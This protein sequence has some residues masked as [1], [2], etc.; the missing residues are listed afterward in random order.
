[1]PEIVSLLKRQIYIFASVKVKKY[2]VPTQTGFNVDWSSTVFR[3]DKAHS[4][5]VPGSGLEVDNS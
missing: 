5:K 2:D 4:T 1:M 3:H